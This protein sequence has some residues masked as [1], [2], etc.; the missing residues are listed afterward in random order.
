MTDYDYTYHVSQSALM[1]SEWAFKSHETCCTDVLPDGCRDIIV[2]ECAGQAPIL[3]LSELSQSTYTVATQGGARLRGMRLRPGIHVQQAELRSWLQG[4]NPAEIFNANQLSE[5]C[6]EQDNL[7]CALECL[8]SGMGTVL[9]AA[10]EQGVSVRTLERLVKTGTG[11]SPYFWFSLARIRKTARA[12]YESESLGVTALEAGFT[13][14]SHMNREMKRW[15]R[16]TP[17]Q[18]IND[19]YFRNTLLEPGYG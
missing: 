17:T 11:R 19:D 8:A 16:K 3:F 5:F 10:K 7:S 6:L 12:L 1:L 2:E 15:F 18:I 9:D 13:D 14:Q 4:R